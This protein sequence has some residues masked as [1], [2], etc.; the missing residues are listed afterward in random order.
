MCGEGGAL[1]VNDERWVE[2]AEII[3]EKGTNRRKFFRGQVDKYSW[4]DVGSSYPLS[5]MNAAFLWAQLEAAD[6]DHSRSGSRPG[7]ATTRRSRELEATE[8]RAAADRSRATASTTRTCTTSARRRASTATRSSSG[9]TRTACRRS[10]TTSRCTR[11]PREADSAARRD[12][13]PVTDRV[14]ERLVRLPLWTGMTAEERTRVV[15]SV[16]AAVADVPASAAGRSSAR[17]TVADRPG[18]DPDFFEPLAGVEER[19]F[20]FQARNRLIVSTM[21]RCFP[22]A[23]SF[24]EIGCGSG[25]VLAAVRAQFPSLRLV[26]GELY[27]EGLAIARRRVPDAELI[28]LDARKLQYENEF[29]VVGAFDVLEHIDEDELVLAHMVRAVRPGGGVLVLVPQHRG[30]G[31]S[32]TSSSSTAGATRARTSWRRRSA[33]GS[34][35]SRRPPSSR[36]CCRRWRSRASSTAWE[37]TDPIANLEPGPLNGLFERMLDGERKLIEHGVSLPFGGSLMLVGRKPQLP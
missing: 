18:F 21:R 32:T 1:L 27:E 20:W 23:A 24:L 26:G 12:Q 9:S 10:S 2:R 36:R 3:H 33:R 15:E 31:A 7:T 6:R 17:M 5:D 35:C 22:E 11:R 28:A 34:R 37:A 29:D 25:I 4:V 14:G 30:C 8:L 19:S 13:L 16:H